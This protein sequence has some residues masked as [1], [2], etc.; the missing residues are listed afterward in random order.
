MKK[1]I[2]LLRYYTLVT[3]DLDTYRSHNR[4][5]SV[6]DLVR[7]DLALMSETSRFKN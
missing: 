2:Y 4:L 3:N 6:D 7:A 1:N 5:S